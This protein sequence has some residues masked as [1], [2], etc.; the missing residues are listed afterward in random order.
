M[1]CGRKPD[2]EPK[3]LGPYRDNERDKWTYAIVINGVRSWYRGRKGGSRQEIEAEIEGARQELLMPV[4]KT[5]SDAIEA[6]AADLEKN[7]SR[8]TAQAT[9]AALLF[10]RRFAGELLAR[11]LADRHVVK[12]LATMDQPIVSANRRNAKP[13]SMATKRS[14]F[15]TLTRAS[16]WWHRHHFMPRDFVA[17]YLARRVEPLP[18]L[19]KAGS[20]Q[21]NRGK[22]QLRNLG[23]ARRYMEQALARPTAEERVAAALPLLTGVSSGELLHIQA[24][25]VDF[26]AGV[27][28][29]RSSET[30][31]E[32][33]D[34]I[35]WSVKTCHRV[36]AVTIPDQLRDDIAELI[37]GLQPMQ[38]LFRAIDDN[39]R[40]GVRADWKRKDA[41]RAPNWLRSV[42][43]RV[44]RDAGVRMVCPH[45]LRATHASLR[46]SVVDEAVS[47]IGDALGHA[48]H[49]K[50]A[51]AHYVGVQ[52]TV[53]VLKLMAG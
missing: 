30:D 19:T 26:E 9:K 32:D 23:E 18:W 17:E 6:Y 48:D 7:T 46:A 47:R 16:T 10:L 34:D 4:D 42:V 51:A 37:E 39:T 50:T 8:V 53:P 38:L 33:N 20:K 27:I 5:V 35:G 25:A 14:Y 22:A 21:M 13:L 52:P 31:D 43:K 1:G 15:L 49:G 41:P 28:H 40:L 11:N 44:C 29:V 36:R 3:V 2:P 45:G 12:F 24:G